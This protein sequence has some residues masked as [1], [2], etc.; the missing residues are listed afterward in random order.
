MRVVSEYRQRAQAYR[1]LAKLAANPEDSGFFE[2]MAHN[3]DLLADLRIGDIESEDQST[4]V[5]ST[6][7]KRFRSIT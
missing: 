4:S 3:L 6:S 7:P 5:P 1:E 2:D